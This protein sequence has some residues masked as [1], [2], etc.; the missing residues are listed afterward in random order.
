MSNR[1]AAASLDRGATVRSSPAVWYG[2]VGAIALAVRLWHL[3]QILPA[4]FYDLLIGDAAAYDDRAR[5]IAS[6]NWL[7]DQVFYQAPLYP[8]FMAVLYSLAGRSVSIVRYVQ[9]VLG[10]I[11]CTL[12]AGS[13]RLLGSAS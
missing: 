3:H 13:G 10:A 8:Y 2:L 5:A 6:G 12:L 11:S 9:A 7:G 1:R 4:P